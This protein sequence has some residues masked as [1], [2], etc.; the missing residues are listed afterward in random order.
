M[1]YHSVVVG[2]GDHR[3]GR[4]PPCQCHYDYSD[5]HVFES[6]KKTFVF[7]LELIWRSCRCGRRG[8]FHSGA[9]QSPVRP[10][11]P[12]FDA[13]VELRLQRIVDLRCKRNL[14]LR[15]YGGP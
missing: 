8:H 10:G 12:F 9:K 7:G 6:A 3:P 11:S 13:S 2:T 15:P 1:G 4:L 14:R 5:F